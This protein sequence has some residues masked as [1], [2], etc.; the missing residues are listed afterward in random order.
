MFIGK[1][2]QVRGKIIELDGGNHPTTVKVKCHRDAAFTHIR[3][4]MKVL[5]RAFVNDDL[6]L[7]ECMGY[8]PTLLGDGFDIELSNASALVTTSPKYRNIFS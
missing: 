6:S 4:S 2:T 8:S 3:K 7:S 1:V 5:V